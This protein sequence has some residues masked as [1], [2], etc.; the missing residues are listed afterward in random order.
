MSRPISLFGMALVLSVASLARAQTPVVQ[1]NVTISAPVPIRSAPCVQAATCRDPLD[2]SI[3]ALTS[4]IDRDWLGVPCAPSKYTI[5]G[6][7]E[8]MLAFLPGSSTPPLITSSPN[9]VPQ[10]TA[11]VLGQPSTSTLFGGNSISSNPYS[12]LRLT[13]GMWLSSTR[14]VEISG[15]FLAER[16]TSFQAGGSGASDSV[17]VGRPFIDATTGKETVAYSAFAGQ[18]GGVSAATMNTS[19]WGT[20][21]NALFRE[22]V[23]NR[24]QLTLLAG[25]RYLNLD[26]QLEMIDTATPQ[27]TATVP[28]AGL[29]A[30]SNPNMVR[31]TDSFQTRNQFLGGQLGLRSKVDVGKFEVGLGGKIAFGATRQTLTINGQS[32]GLASNGQLLIMTPGGLLANNSNMGSYS[33]TVAGIVPEF[34]VKVSYRVTENFSVFASYN[35]LYWDNVA[36][37]GNQVSRSVN[38][39]NVPTSAVYASAPGTI[40]AATITSSD[41]SV[42]T[43]MFGGLLKF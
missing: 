41:F 6:S 31:V 24:F 8:Y 36:N 34:E 42:N 13:A 19:L 11:A 1:D 35:F 25:G 15:F 39:K 10:G 38:L 9:G 40:G 18:L 3:D 7:A 2:Q 32:E 29:L 17:A 14:G 12:G 30:I 20:E 21:I 23:S 28:F 5:W 22:E 43:F 26:Q 33:R 16:S 27:G 37:V 4:S